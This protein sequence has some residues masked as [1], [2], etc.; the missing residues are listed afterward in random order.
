MA[1]STAAAVTAGDGEIKSVG[2]RWAFGTNAG[3]TAV[4]LA[5]AE[6]RRGMNLA[7]PRGTSDVAPIH[8]VRWRSASD[9]PCLTYIQYVI[10]KREVLFRDNV[11]FQA[12]Q[13]MRS[14][15]V[16]EPTLPDGEVAAGSFGDR[17]SRDPRHFR[18]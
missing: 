9:E 11:R 5:V 8:V 10:V 2:L 7:V 6:D 1:A 18:R 17:N 12:L 15:L 13:R 4:G 14:A 16:L 3:V